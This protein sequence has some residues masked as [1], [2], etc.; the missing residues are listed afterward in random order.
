[1]IN[2]ILKKAL[3]FAGGLATAAAFTAA[4]AQVTTNVISETTFDPAAAS[5]WGY[6]Y[7][8]SNNGLGTQNYNRAYY[9]P[10][11]VDMTNA[12][13]QYTFDITDLNGTTGYGTG[14]GGPLFLADTTTGQLTSTN[15]E[16]YLFSFDAR[17][18]GLTDAQA[19]ANAEMQVQFYYPDENNTAVKVLQVNLPFQVTADWKRYTFDLSQGALGDNTSDTAF[20]LR[21]AEIN[22]VRF[23]V[24]L[25]E[26]HTAFGYDADNEFYLDNVKLEVVNR[27]STPPVPMRGVTVV[28]WNFDDKPV[29]NEYHYEW[30]QNDFHAT[31]TAGNN[32][33]GSNTNDLGT[34]GTSG[35]FLTLD[36]TAM[37]DNPPQ[38]AGGGTGGGGP[39]DY[40]QFNTPD[41]SLYRLSFDARVLGLA[42]DYTNS[43]AV[44][45]LFLDAPDDTLQPPDENTDADGLVRLDFPITQVSSNWQNYTFILNKG[46]VG[47]GNKTNFQAAFDK[48]SAL[49]TQWQIENATAPNWGFD[50]DNTLVID[51]FK[52]ERLYPDASGPTI[53]VARDANNLVLTWSGAA[54]GTTLKLQSAADVAGPYTEVPN[55]TSG[56]STPMTGKARFFRLVQES[57]AQ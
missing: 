30:S 20:A 25:H 37:L 39:V 44:L 42:E 41:L 50:A 10:E 52:L 3:V 26:P 47:S 4:Q 21:H 11:D 46:G 29:D 51:N 1:M 6:G 14:T 31:P 49:R 13:W 38:W 8:Y 55:A 9:F 33:I 24:N 57:A 28:D 15:R 16:D 19:P 17:A 35:W 22:D 48:I 18:A 53:S 40:T 45:Q 56:Y 5:P 2:R 23:N 43:A 12:V 27:P 34:D 32:A 7:F 54:S 36:T